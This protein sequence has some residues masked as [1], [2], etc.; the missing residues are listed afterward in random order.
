MRASLETLNALAETNQTRDLIADP[1]GLY[2]YA[3]R[4]MSP[5]RRIE[6]PYPVRQLKMEKN[7]VVRGW[8]RRKRVSGA[9]K[10]RD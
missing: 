10:R 9:S 3:G 7:R 8:R 6:K 4:R 2:L 1:L 5:G